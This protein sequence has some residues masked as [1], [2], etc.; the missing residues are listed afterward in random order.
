VGAVVGTLDENSQ[1]L[2]LKFFI[3]V[4]LLAAGLP[5]AGKLLAAP[6][7]ARSKAY[8]IDAECKL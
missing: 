6:M 1:F 5:P 3:G 8:A 7:L 4:L 2:T